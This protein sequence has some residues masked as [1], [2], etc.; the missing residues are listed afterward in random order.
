MFGWLGLRGAYT[1]L[2][3]DWYILIGDALVWT[4]LINSVSLYITFFT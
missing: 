1:T 2:S 4:M 3:A